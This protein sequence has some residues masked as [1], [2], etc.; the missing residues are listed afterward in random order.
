MPDEAA[1][2]LRQRHDAIASRLDSAASATERDAIKAEIITLYKETEQQISALNA[3]REDIKRLVER[4]KALPQPVGESRTPV[5]PGAPNTS[6]DNRL[7]K[8]SAPRPSP[9]RTCWLN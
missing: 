1:A 7:A 5:T 4:W 2:A 9:Q 3:L 6:S 8:P